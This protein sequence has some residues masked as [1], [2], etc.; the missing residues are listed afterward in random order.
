MDNIYSNDLNV[1][2][3]IKKDFIISKNSIKINEKINNNLHGILICY[4]PWCSHCVLTRDLWI[5]LSELFKSKFNFFSLN[6]YNFNDKNQDLVKN[7]KI[8]VYPTYKLIDKNGY[9]QDYYG[10]KKEDEF[11]QYIMAKITK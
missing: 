6:T 10:G 3:L 4:A 1:I 9:I 7:L 8:S 5:K 11:I 2:E